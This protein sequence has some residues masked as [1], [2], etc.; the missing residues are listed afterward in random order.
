MALRD[1]S[2]FRLGS[3]PVTIHPAA[4]TDDFMVIFPGLSVIPK[5][6]HFFGQL[7]IIHRA[8]TGLA[9]KFLPEASCEPVRRSVYSAPWA[10]NASRER[11]LPKSPTPV[12]LSYC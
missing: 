2:A 11:N 4:G 7:E 6:R 8:A 3:R 5:E 10:S 12:K 1:A 9:I